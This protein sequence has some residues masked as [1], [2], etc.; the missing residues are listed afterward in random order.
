M[1]S[2]N[3]YINEIKNYRHFDIKRHIIEIWCKKICEIDG[4]KSM[5]FEKE[6]YFKILETAIKAMKAYCA[7]EDISIKEFFNY[8]M[9]DKINLQYTSFIKFIKNVREPYYESARSSSSGKYFTLDC[10][11]KVCFEYPEIIKLMKTIL[12]IDR[13]T[14]ELE[15][16]YTDLI[17]KMADIHLLELRHYIA[18]T[19]QH[20]IEK[21]DMESVYDSEVNR[22]IYRKPY[23]QRYKK[24]SK[25]KFIK[26]EHKQH[27]QGELL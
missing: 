12:Q 7:I 3:I 2:N 22:I 11:L 17:M 13:D 8:K 16:I 23:L 10:L 26:Y 5:N 27:T 15:P 18:E 9:R 1:I 4:L 24:T 25:G 19:K 14:R 6:K 20:E 21:E